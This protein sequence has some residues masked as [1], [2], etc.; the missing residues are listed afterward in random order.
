MKDVFP[1]Y[2][3]PTDA[4]F[5]QL[6]DKCIFVLDANVLLNLYRYSVDTRKKLLGTMKHLGSRLWVPHQAAWEYQR[7]RLDVICKQ[8]EAYT[9]IERVFLDTRRK[10]ES[11]LGDYSKHPLIDRESILGPINEAFD[12]QSAELSKIREKHPNLV[13]EDPVR[14]ELTGLLKNRVG[15]AYSEDKLGQLYKEGESRY[16]KQVPPGYLD[17][18][19]KDG[20]RKF[21]DFILWQQVIDK[22]SSEKKPIIVITDDA[23]EDWWW[24]HQG[25]VI[26]PRPELV[27]EVRRIAGVEFYMYR[28]DQFLEFSAPYLKQKVDESAIAEVREVRKHDEAR[29]L[30]TERQT[31]LNSEERRNFFLRRRLSLEKQNV[32]SELNKLTGEMQELSNF[33]KTEDPET[34]S[35]LQHEIDQQIMSA[36]GRLKEI[37]D[38]LAEVKASIEKD[39][40]RPSD[41]MARST[42]GE[43][44]AHAIR[45]IS[46]K[47]PVAR[48]AVPTSAFRR[49]HDDSEK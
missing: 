32:L 27:E 7:N 46:L 15:G 2:Y 37:D 26:G 44:L 28:S 14:D 1:G 18:K 8:G 39:R 5:K 23:K 35:E 24:K 21:G 11:A 34:V 48:Y 22:A 36:L 30:A 25:K 42:A 41:A 45:A 38:G 9:E 13:D 3:R 17:A 6:W 43:S 20:E 16:S 4:E 49:E 29:I 47:P 40:P 31:R 10:L 33:A 12:R 19:T